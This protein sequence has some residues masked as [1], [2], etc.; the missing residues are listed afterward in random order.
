MPMCFKC[1]TDFQGSRCPNCGTEV[2][3]AE[4]PVWREQS[5]SVTGASGKP[6]VKMTEPPKSGGFKLITAGPAWGQS[7][8]MKMLGWMI[9]SLLGTYLV[10]PAKKAPKPE[11][12]APAD[13]EAAPTAA[14]APPVAAE[15]APPPAPPT[16]VAV[17][18]TPELLPLQAPAPDWSGMLVEEIGGHGPEEWLTEDKAHGVP[19]LPWLEGKAGIAKADVHADG[20][21][22]A[23]LVY[24]EA[25][26]SP[27]WAAF[28]KEA[29]ES[30][31]FVVL[32]RHF[33][34]LRV[35]TADI[36]ALSVLPAP[37]GDATGPGLYAWFGGGKAVRV[38]VEEGPAQLPTRDWRY[39]RNQLRHAMH[40]EVIRKVKDGRADGLV[41]QWADAEQAF[42]AALAG[43]PWCAEA[44]FWRGVVRVLQNTPETLAGAQRDMERAAELDRSNPSQAMRTAQYLAYLLAQGGDLKA[45]RQKLEEAQ[46][47]KQAEQSDELEFLLAAVAIRLGDE[48]AAHRALERSCKLGKAEACNALGQHM[49]TAKEIQAGT[50]HD[51]ARA[52]A[53]ERAATA[54]AAAS[55]HKDGDGGG[56]GGGSGS[57]DMDKMLGDAN[58]ISN[59]GGGPDAC[60]VALGACSGKQGTAADACVTGIPT[61]ARGSGG[62]NCCPP[63]CG[64]R[65]AGLKKTG[66]S[67]QDCVTVL[68]AG[69]DACRSNAASTGKIGQM[70]S[71]AG[72]FKAPPPPPMPEVPA[73]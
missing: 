63:T 33:S 17:R 26:N 53:D 50:M 55:V 22:A 65:Y 21:H 8:P 54:K 16:P 57:K 25:D 20:K 7:K 12:V 18:L 40:P 45:A 28:R 69:D 36:P 48:A 60:S 1:A 73:N 37:I 52:A 58:A 47:V 66:K 10:M 23:L 6:A 61:C 29:L 2:V 44:Y 67:P 56:G 3:V 27:Q 15:A 24:I 19:P 41:R 51:E 30:P 71:A 31:E 42:T 39:L 14:A 38:T 5:I 46:Q 4:Q 49:V 70:P 64:A 59:G 62:Q 43:D 68:T 72:G 34:K 13:G 32:G 35:K 9:T 11:A